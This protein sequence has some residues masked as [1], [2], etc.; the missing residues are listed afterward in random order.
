MKILATEYLKSV[1]SP[2]NLSG[3]PF[4][5]ICFV[6][7]SNV[8]KSSMIN[9]LVMQKVARTSSTPGATRTINLYK[10]SYE[11]RG[12]RKSILF[13]DF[14]GFGYAKVSKAVYTG[15]QKM[16]EAY[17]SQNS[18]I[19][20]LI[21]VYDVRRDIDEL[22]RTL[23]DWLHSLRLDFTMV[24]TKIDKESRSKVMSKK[25]LFSRYFGD[26]RVFTFS[27]KDGYGRKELLSHI[28]DAGE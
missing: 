3:E 25:G 11:F 17:V 14:A 9:K 23:I 5:E 27:A 28:F 6:G 10:V 15:W 21:W 26:S 20:K 4:P 16:I 19:E 7:R 22:D 13:S 1:T 12:S 8:G 24:L 18:R 2:D